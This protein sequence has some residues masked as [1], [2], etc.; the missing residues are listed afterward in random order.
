MMEFT[1]PLKFRPVLCALATAI[2]CEAGEPYRPA[3][4]PGN[5]S[6][7]VNNPYFPL[8]PGTTTTFTEHDGRET[9]ENKIT[10]TRE[11]KSVMG[12]KCVVVHDTVTREGALIDDTRAYYAQDKQ[13]AVWIFGE[14]SKEFLSFG[15]LSTDGSWEAGV[16][17]AQPG[18]MM[19][20]RPKV[21]DRYRQEYL[22]NVAEDIGQIAALNQTVTVPR[23]TFT[24]CVRT[25]EWSML[26][27]GTSK[28]W[29]AK[30]VG[31]VRDECT[32]GEVSA[33]V[34]ITRK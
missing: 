2:A 5:F 28:K 33:L 11:T 12:V 26:D 1:S 34:S 31:L 25:R 27:S 3:I 21:G 4:V 32:D 15:R 22:A 17:G 19:P 29:Y 30:G 16:N 20:A 10:V 13:G 24:D 9:R 18:I 8:V 7:V 6:P 23:G 14:A